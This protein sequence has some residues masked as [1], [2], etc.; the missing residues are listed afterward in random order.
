[1]FGV[2]SVSGVVGAAF[3]V[4]GAWPVAG[5]LGLGVLVLYVAFRLALRRAR[6]REHIRIDAEGLFV[7]RIDAD[8]T[9]HEW[10]FEPCWVCVQMDDPPHCDSRLTLA[11]PGLSLRVGA[12]LTPHER[13]D[14]A[15][16]L[17]AALLRY[18]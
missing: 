12:F 13:L 1:L 10:R 3:A 6:Q 17:Q 4:V 8:G 15:R 7:R 5:F 14:L 18:R 16:A 2:S 11:S 9:A